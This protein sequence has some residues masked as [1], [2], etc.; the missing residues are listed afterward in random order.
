M[1]IIVIGSEMLLTFTSNQP[2]HNTHILLLISEV[3]EEKK[4]V[5]NDY[6]SHSLSIVFLSD[7]ELKKSCL[8]GRLE[9][10]TA[11]KFSVGI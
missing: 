7:L 2:H 3:I 5:F 1:P 10:L 6:S 4:F 8:M 9:V 11:Q